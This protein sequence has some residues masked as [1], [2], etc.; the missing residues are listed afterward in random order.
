[1]DFWSDRDW[2]YDSLVIVPV[3]SSGYFEFEVKEFEYS[4]NLIIWLERVPGKGFELYL[5]PGYDLELSI[6]ASQD[7][8]FQTVSFKGKGAKPNN[9]LASENR[10]KQLDDLYWNSAMKVPDE[11]YTAILEKRKY[12]KD[13]LLDATF[14][15]KQGNIIAY[16]QFYKDRKVENEFSLNKNILFRLIHNKEV[17]IKE[18][19]EYFQTFINP[20]LK[21]ISNYEEYLHI[22]SVKMF[23]FYSYPDYLVLLED[24]L[25]N[26]AKV[27][28]NF[29]PFWIET[30]Q[31]FYPAGKIRKA[32]IAEKLEV[33]SMYEASRWKRNYSYD[34]LLEVYKSEIND[35]IYFN[36]LRTAYVERR[37]KLNEFVKLKGD[38]APDFTLHDENGNFYKLTDFKGKNLLIDVWA[39][40]CR[41][42][43]SEM[44]TLKKMFVEFDTSN[45]QIINV[46]VDT[47]RDKWLKAKKKHNP[48]GLQ[49]YAEGGNQSQFAKNYLVEF[50]P[51]YI[52]I[53]KQSNVF[54]FYAKKAEEGKLENE[55]KELLAT[56]P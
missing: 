14:L 41:P 26:Q 21:S 19:I 49:L 52:L 20:K 11:D 40:W 48:I 55:V 13:S 7:N 3:D 16:P 46:S 53:D 47:Q 34:S 25:A 54:S 38:K 44:P 23:Y 36:D 31:G 24:S 50:L 8:I 27:A 39:S 5:E 4:K 43:I 1:M 10:N 9:F 17:D 35:E 2:G 37:K 33:V 42:C 22:R 51:R 28:G 6:D 45:L 32:T 15:D 18:A 56:I 12:L 30:V 29:E